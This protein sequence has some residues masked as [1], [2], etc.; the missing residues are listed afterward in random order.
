VI[1]NVRYFFILFITKVKS[2][3]YQFPYP[4]I[5]CLKKSNLKD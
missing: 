1:A 3:R 5:F 2:G 4:H